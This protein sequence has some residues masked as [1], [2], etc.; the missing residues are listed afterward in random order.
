MKVSDSGNKHF[1]SKGCFFGITTIFLLM[2]CSDNRKNGKYNAEK[3]VEK[4]HFV[5][6]FQPFLNDRSTGK[7]NEIE[8]F[9]IEIK[10]VDDMD[11]VQYLSETSN[12]TKEE[13]LYYLSYRLKDDIFL[14]D[15]DRKRENVIFHFERS[16]DL[17][18]GRLFNVG[19]E[20]ENKENSEVTLVIDSELLNVGPVKLKFIS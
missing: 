2:A 17:K 20:P 1:F 6:E 19:F 9:K 5:I 4:L 10:H 8:Y 3:V 15:R 16:F 13:V 14:M 7:D 12:L 11:L 18:K